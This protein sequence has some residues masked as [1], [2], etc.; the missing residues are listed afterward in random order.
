MINLILV[1]LTITLS[2]EATSFSSS[3][4][5]L[6]K[7]VYYDNQFTFYCNN[8]Y[9]IKLVQGKQKALIIQDDKYYTPRKPY[10]KSGKPNYRAKRIEWEHIMPAHNFGKHLPCWK[11][12]GRKACKKDKLF[13]KMEADM[14]NLVPAIGE[15]NADRSNYR[16]GADKLIIGQYGSCEMQVDFKAKRAY[17]RDDIKGD[18]ARA[19]LYMSKKYD[20][21][22]SKQEKQMMEVWNKLDPISEWEITKQTR[23]SHY[24]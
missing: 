2:L 22:L 3:K 6:L 19:Y 11:K 13:K 23:I 18:I 5:T 8:P 10:F 17:V 14:H 20:I 16:Y 15:V 21:K 12:G 4:K 9:E 24:Q 7:K 1:I